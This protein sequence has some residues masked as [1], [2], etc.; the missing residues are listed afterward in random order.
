MRKRTRFYNQWRRDQDYRERL[1]PEEK[2]WLDK[3]DDEYYRA[4]FGEDPLH[5]TPELRNDVYARQ[6]AAARDVVT[7]TG[8][9]VLESLAKIGAVERPS[10]RPRFYSPTDYQMFAP[11][12]PLDPSL[13]E[14]LAEVRARAEPLQADQSTA[15]IIELFPPKA[16]LKKAN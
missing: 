1:S 14:K 2:A 6:N 9:Q 13:V 12:Q 11:N 7:A 5:G 3:F 10:L 16:P 4:D 8:D 15:E